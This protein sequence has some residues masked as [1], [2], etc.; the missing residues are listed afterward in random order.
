MLS[1]PIFRIGKQ[2]LG[3]API[4]N[5]DRRPAAP[6]FAAEHAQF[7]LLLKLLEH[8]RHGPSNGPPLVRLPD[9]VD[10][11]ADEEDDEA[12]VEL[13]KEA[14]AMNHG[15]RGLEKMA[16]R[17]AHGHEKAAYS[18]DD[19]DPLGSVCFCGLDRGKLDLCT[20][21][22]RLRLDFDGHD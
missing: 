10:A 14:F 21:E 9:R 17:L 2:V 6:H 1:I 7:R 19:I 3:A 4:L 13:S 22:T 16:N 12:A 15:V 11:H 8:A 20:V 18:D 5:Q